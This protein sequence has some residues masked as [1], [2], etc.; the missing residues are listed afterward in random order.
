MHRN[1]DIG[2][3]KGRDELFGKTPDCIPDYNP[4]H[5]I[6]FKYPQVAIRNL[7]LLDLDPLQEK[8]R[9]SIKALMRNTSHNLH[10]GKSYKNFFDINDIISKKKDD[11]EREVIDEQDLK[12]I[13]QQLHS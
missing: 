2:K 10:T 7:Y 5:N 8:S 4:D 3:F 12:M 13:N 1:I 11:R 9:N 6:R